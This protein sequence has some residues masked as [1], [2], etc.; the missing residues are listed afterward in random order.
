MSMLKVD[1]FLSG[2]TG[3]VFMTLSV[4]YSVSNLHCPVSNDHVGIAI[5][6]DR[7]SDITSQATVLSITITSQSS[8]TQHAL[9][10][11][12]NGH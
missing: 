11:L 1:E 10:R 5:T 6:T 12:Q 9:I 7:R 2:L 3:T 4:N 8:D